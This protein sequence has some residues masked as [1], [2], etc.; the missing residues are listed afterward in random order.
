MFSHHRRCLRPR[1]ERRFPPA[2]SAGVLP[3]NPTC[4]R[5]QLQWTHKGLPFVHSQRPHAPRQVSGRLAVLGGLPRRVKLY[6]PDF[7]FEQ[8]Q[9]DAP[10]V[11][12]F[13]M[14]AAL[15]RVTGFLDPGPNPHQFAAPFRFY[16]H[17][18]HDS[19]SM[20]CLSMVP[21]RWQATLADATEPAQTFSLAA[22]HTGSDTA[23]VRQIKLPRR[24][25]P[26]V[27]G[28]PL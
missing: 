23:T 20:P 2:W 16:L 19:A 13:R 3:S 11:M 14:P 24:A 18:C 17:C 6:L 26:P 5:T 12:R 9:H 25:T 4:G 27:H 10:V 28:T 21:L 7:P 8:V 22:A 15:R 1:A